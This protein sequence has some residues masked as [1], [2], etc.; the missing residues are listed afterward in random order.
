MDDRLKEIKGI[1][2]RLPEAHDKIVKN[3]QIRFDY[4][5]Y[6]IPA[7]ENETEHSDRLRIEEALL[8]MK[9]GDQE[10][11]SKDQEPGKEENRVKPDDN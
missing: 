6:L 2:D 4:S 8:L 9:T 3:D 1:L 7:S 5:V 11:G 10:S